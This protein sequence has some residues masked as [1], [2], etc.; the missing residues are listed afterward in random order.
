MGVLTEATYPRPTR[1]Q[2]VDEALRCVPVRHR[3]TLGDRRCVA[4]LI[5]ASAP[6]KYTL[7]RSSSQRTRYRS[8][9]QFTQDFEDLGDA[10]G[11]ANVVAC[12][13]DQIPDVGCMLCG[14]HV[15]LL[16]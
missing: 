2:F 12:D 5:V 13:N 16:S 11:L 1:L 7:S 14:R 3:A 9:G 6:G 15:I 8:F 4:C 10:L